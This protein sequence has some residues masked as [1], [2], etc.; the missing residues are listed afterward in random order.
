MLANN[1]NNNWCCF[2]CCCDGGEMKAAA[3]M[4]F[5][6]VILNAQKLKF[7]VCWYF[8]YAVVWIMKLKPMSF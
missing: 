8:D 1:A 3:V 2:G 4:V 7:L 5:C 6:L